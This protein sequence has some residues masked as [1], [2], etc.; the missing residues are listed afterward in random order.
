MCMMRW[1]QGNMHDKYDAI[2]EEQVRGRGGRL[3]QPSS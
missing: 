1:I 3:M 2:E